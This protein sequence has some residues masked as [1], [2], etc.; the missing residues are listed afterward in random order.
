MTYKNWLAEWLENYIRT[1]NKT[2]TY[3]RYKN[4]IAI[5]INPHLGDY[6][7][8][9]IS[10]IILQ[11][12]VSTLLNKDNK[13][14]QKGLSPSYIACI[15]AVVK[16][17][18]K[19]ANTLGIIN[20][21]DANNVKLP[22]IIE[23]QVDCFSVHEQKKVENYILNNHKAQLKGIIICLYT[24]LRIG[25]LLALTWDD[26]NFE[27]RTLNISKSCHDGYTDGKH[28]VVMDTPKTQNSARQIPLSKPIIPLLKELKKNSKC[29]YVI[30]YND[31]PILVRTYQ[32][33]FE[34]L[35]KR[36]NI[37][38]KGFHATRHTFATRAIECGMDVKTLSEILGHK[39]ATITLNRY[40]HS[41]WEHK[42][43]MM[44]SLGKML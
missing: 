33:T 20:K 15:M 26:I 37:P 30:S 43:D 27:K 9:D 1:S 12:F 7:T 4:M 42:A 6:E 25:E 39:N 35:L 8:D 41:L 40:A 11:K 18:L 29:D 10:A 28:C 38:H 3:E 16:S 44:N 2:R 14:T 31:K 19:T 23:K 34:L 17:S 13:R 24:G 32:R 5:H 21:F 36:L 22:K